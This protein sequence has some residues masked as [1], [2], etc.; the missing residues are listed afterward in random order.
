VAQPAAQGTPRLPLATAL[1]PA[2]QLDRTL[3]EIAKRFG[4]SGS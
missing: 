3:G 1:K 4:A 2:Q